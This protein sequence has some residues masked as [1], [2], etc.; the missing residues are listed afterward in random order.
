MYQVDG[1]NISITR[2]DSQYIKI[3]IEDA[4]GI[5]YTLDDRDKVRCEVRSS[6]NGGEILFEGL[7]T[8][9]SGTKEIV[10]HIR[11][12]DTASQSIKTYYYDMQL[13]TYNGDVFT[14]IPVS[15]FKLLDEVTLKN[16]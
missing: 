6:K 1:T 13:E 5:L 16:E 14:F 4:S 11:P 12:E 10:W 3:I 8:V 7:I 2:G 15:T 9:N